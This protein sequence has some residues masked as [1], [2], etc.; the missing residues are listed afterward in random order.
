MSDDKIYFDNVIV[1]ASST[2]SFFLKIE[3]K[4]IDEDT[5]L[6]IIY[7]TTTFLEA[8][9]AQG[10]HIHQITVN[11]RHLIKLKFMRGRSE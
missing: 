1:L 7:G 9:S 8:R 3:V 10:A 11:E 5:R 6:M 4:C 2:T